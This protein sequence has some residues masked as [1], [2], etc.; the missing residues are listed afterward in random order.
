MFAATCCCCPFSFYFLQ[1]EVKRAKVNSSQRLEVNRKVS[2]EVE[3][4]VPSGN[5][6][7]MTRNIPQSFWP[8]TG[9]ERKQG[10]TT[11][12]TSDAD[13]KASCHEQRWYAPT[14]GQAV[15]QL[16]LDGVRLPLGFDTPG[17][18]GVCPKSSTSRHRASMALVIATTS[19][20]VHYPAG[21]PGPKQ[22]G[23]RGRNSHGSTP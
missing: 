15:L 5:F 12:S 6:S 1:A 20:H 23:G 11:S 13:W 2:V 21:C 18:A 16:V 22:P 19:C 8:W 9:P 3:E 4:K 7:S 17:I 14:V 10:W